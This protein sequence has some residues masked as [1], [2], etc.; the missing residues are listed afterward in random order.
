MYDNETGLFLFCDWLMD[1]DWFEDGD[2][3]LYIVPRP[4]IVAEIDGSDG[5]LL[6]AMNAACRDHDQLTGADCSRLGLSRVDDVLKRFD[7]FDGYYHA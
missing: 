5:P 1:A 2:G 6:D 4:H 3:M 7:P